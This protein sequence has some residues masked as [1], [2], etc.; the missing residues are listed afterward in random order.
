VKS[1]IVESEV[2]MMRTL[3]PTQ[4]AVRFFE[5][6]TL[7]EAYLKALGKGLTRS[8]KSVVFRFD[9]DDAV[10]LTDEHEDREWTFVLAALGDDCT[11]AVAIKRRQDPPTVTF[12]DDSSGEG[13]RV[14]VLR[15]SALI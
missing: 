3:G 11:L 7:K 14:R 2:E 12:R 10:G 15:T 6:W 13:G 5:L 8:L 1:G 9:D 4:A